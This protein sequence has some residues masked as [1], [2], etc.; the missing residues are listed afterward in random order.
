M[1]IYKR[2]NAYLYVLVYVDDIIIAGDDSLVKSFHVSLAAQF[3]LKDLEELSFLGIEATC[4]KHGLHLMQRKYIIDLL[5][6]MHM[7]DVK[8]ISISMAPSPKLSLFSG[9]P[10]DDATEYICVIG[11]L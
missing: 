8:P 6:K 10:L 11:S 1:F 2:K 3:S 4:T 7:L 5:A 9:T